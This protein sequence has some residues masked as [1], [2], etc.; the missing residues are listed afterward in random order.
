MIVEGV[1]FSTNPL[2]SLLHS[3]TGLNKAY[4]LPFIAME[5]AHSEKD[6]KAL[7][8]ALV[9]ACLWEG[10][11]GIWQAMYGKD[12]IMGYL[13]NAGR[14]TG[15][16]GDYT[17]GNYLAL[18]L[19]PAWGVWFILREK[20]SFCV[21]LL[22]MCALFWPALFL[23][24]GASSRSGILALAGAAAIWAYMTYPKLNWRILIWPALI[25]S[26]FMLCQPG[27]IGLASTVNDNRWDLWSLAWRVFL[28]YPIWG[29]GTGQYNAAFQSLGLRPEREVITISHPHDLYLDLL[30]A[31]GLVGFSLGMLFLFGFLFWAYRKFRPL[32]LKERGESLLYWRLGACFWLAY[33]AWLIN[34]IFGHDFYRTWWLAQ[35][36]SYLGIMAGAIVNGP[37]GQHSSTRDAGEKQE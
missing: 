29:A 17:V 32:L 14:L 10:L 27:R 16:L 6:L 1:L 3:G 19:V 2:A 34:G 28:E 13:P 18:A 35:A 22:L 12:F 7:I 30:Y 26:L 36:M 8:W 31:H 15:S 33:A 9:F 11:D 20:L 4:I 21:C 5:C 37:A 25:L 24:Q 23:F